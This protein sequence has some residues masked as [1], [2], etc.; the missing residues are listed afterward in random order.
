MLRARC[1]HRTGR[2]L[3][4]DSEGGCG[5]SASR[6]ARGTGAR[7]HTA[8]PFTPFSWGWPE[9]NRRR[10]VVATRR[11]VAVPCA[12]LAGDASAARV[13]QTRHSVATSARRRDV[14]PQRQ[15]GPLPCRRQ[16]EI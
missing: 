6:R 1:M 9:R 7:R 13:V 14:E 11:F 8:T 4:H 15:E 2:S 10:S 16:F 12:A 3:D 5:S